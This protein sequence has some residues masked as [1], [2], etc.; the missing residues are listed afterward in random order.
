MPLYEYECSDCG[1]ACEIL[2]TNTQDNP[3]CPHCGSSQMKKLL[4][5]TSTLTGH[6]QQSMPGLGD[7]GCCG[8][9][10]GHANCAG[11]GTCCGKAG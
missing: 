3:Q 8:Q 11:P 6:Q 9:R 7:T 1:K 5:V 10:P 4:S 2:L